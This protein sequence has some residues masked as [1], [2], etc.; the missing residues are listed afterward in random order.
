MTGFLLDFAALAIIGGLIADDIFA[1][2]DIKRLEKQVAELER[3]NLADAEV[4]LADAEEHIE[5]LRRLRSL[6][7]P[8][9]LWKRRSH[10]R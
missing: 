9:D 5:D 8:D 3:L 7:L 2:R 4:N 6:A 10:S 1:R